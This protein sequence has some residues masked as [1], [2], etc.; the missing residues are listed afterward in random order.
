MKSC[1]LKEKW[2]W[3]ILAVLLAA[4]IAHATER[5]LIHGIY[6]STLAQKPYRLMIAELF[7]LFAAFL[8]IGRKVSSGWKRGICIASVM[9]VFLWIHVILVPLMVSGLYLLYICMVGRNIRRDPRFDMG[10]DFLLGSMAVICLFCLMSAAGIGSIPCMTA[11]VIVSGLALVLLEVW[12]WRKRGRRTGGVSR[13]FRTMILGG[14]EIAGR[15]QWSWT[16]AA[17]VAFVLTMFC[18]QAGR[19][20]IALDYD[21]LWYE[22]RSPYILNNGRGIYENLGTMAVVHTYAK[23]WETL[24]LPLSDLPSFGFLMSASLWMAAGAVYTVYL[25]ARYFMGKRRAGF[26]TVFVASIPAVMNMAASAKTD[27]AVVFVQMLMILEI[28]RFLTRKD[29]SRGD[30]CLMAGTRDTALYYG[31]AAMIFSWTIKPTAMVHSTAIC[32]MTFLYLLW[33]R[34]FTLRCHRRNRPEAILTAVLTICELTGMWARTWLITGMPVTSIFSS[35]LSKLGFHLKYPFAMR[36]IPN[37]AS[38]M[39]L[40]EKIRHLAERLYG[41]VL[42]PHDKGDMDHV[43]MVWGCMTVWFFFW[44]AAAILLLKKKRRE[45]PVRRKLSGW[46]AIVFFPFAAVNMASLYLLG[47]VDGNYFM[48][49]Y[50]LL[51]IGGFNLLGRLENG[52]MRLAIESLAIPAILFS[53]VFMTLSNWAWAIGFTPINL[54]HRGYYRH[55]DEWETRLA[56]QGSRAI[57]DILAENPRNRVIV[58]ADLPALMFPCSTQSFVDITGSNGNIYVTDTADDFAEFMEYAGTDYF[59]ADLSWTGGGEWTWD[60][61]SDMV[62]AG[63]LEPVCYEN[64]RM[65]AKVH[66]EGQDPEKTAEAFRYF[67]EEYLYKFVRQ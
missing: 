59:Y 52:S 17:G 63:Y 53:A 11:A 39:G 58:A 10:R 15:G 18:I 51:V 26:V 16:A 67:Q 40:E 41:F 42:S 13:C 65:L 35:V 60:L 34:D 21:T 61:I 19:L 3:L 20:N 50:I 43:I 1:S 9:A 14:E 47:Q 37:T 29:S 23:G 4:G 24:M 64:V 54:I 48:L 38:E 62:E 30:S 25:I 2:I 5:N 31:A 56:D 55:Q 57:W 6:A 66:P 44:T 28:L 8:L 22:V 7:I 32:G 49:F 46:F 45:N 33:N 36:S 12:K 27:M